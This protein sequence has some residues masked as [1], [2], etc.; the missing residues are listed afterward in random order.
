LVILFSAKLAVKHQ[1]ILNSTY[2]NH[3]FIFCE[4]MMEA[5]NYL[6]QATVFVTYGEDM[7][8]DTI[9]KAPNLKWIMVLSAGVERL[10]FQAIEARNILVTNSRGIHKIQMAEYT[11]SMLLQVYRQEKEVIENEKQS[12]WGKV[13]VQEITG[14]TM[15]VLG[16]GAIG[17]EVARLA[18]AFRMKTIGF[19]RSGR[20]AE[21][22]DEVYQINHL[23]QKLPEADFVVSVLPSTNETKYL[24][25][26]EHFKQMKNDAVFVNIGRGDVVASDII[27]RAVQEK[28]IAHA[29]LDVFEQEPL[30]A[31]HPFWKE[32]NITVTP[33][34]SGK[35]PEY[36]PRALSVFRENLHKFLQAEADFINIVSTARGY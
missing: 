9:A 24:L 10:P 18:K 2:P 20:A 11:I 33:H 29:V 35:S 3:T 16:T 34:I 6:D 19:S 21:S 8:E 27:L 5:D 30:P 15:L 25:Q 4:D 17:Q 14:R 1:Q 28:E 7:N 26:A 31:E 13:P 12:I 36:L 23:V 32:P 22:F